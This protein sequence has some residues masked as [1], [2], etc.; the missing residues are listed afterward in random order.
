MGGTGSSW[1]VS[2]ILYHCNGSLFGKDSG[3]SYVSKG[4]IVGMV[5]GM[6]SCSL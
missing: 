2:V 4:D 3:L 1:D 5:M 6:G